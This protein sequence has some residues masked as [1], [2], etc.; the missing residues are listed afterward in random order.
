MVPQARRPLTT[1]GS[2]VPGDANACKPSQAEPLPY[3][4]IGFVFPK[5]ITENQPGVHRIGFVLQPPPHR[6][7]PLAAAGADRGPA[8]GRIVGLDAPSDGRIP[9]RRFPF[10]GQPARLP[11]L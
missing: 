8:G 6:A 9:P 7:L 2:A 5:P 1:A 3:P 11:S 10:V 4:S